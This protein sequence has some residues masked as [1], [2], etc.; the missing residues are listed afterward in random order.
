MEFRSPMR[1]RPLHFLPVILLIALFALVPGRGAAQDMPISPRFGLVNAYEDTEAARLSGAGWEIIT[2][3]W[4]E[5]QPT[6]PTDWTP[7]SEIDNWLSSAR[8]AG[9]EVVV[10]LV[11]TPGWAT[12]GESV[13]GVPRG[14]YLPV[15]DPGNAWGSFVSQAASYYGS[16]GVNRWVIWR[17]IDIPRGRQGA[18]WDGSIEEYYQLVKVASVAA[19][20]AN[21]NALIHLGG[22]GSFDPG[23]F[24]RFLDIALDDP[25]APGSDYY[26]DV[27]TLHVFYSPE[28]VYTQIRNHYYLMDQRGIPLK[29]VWLNETNARPAVDSEV[30]PEDATFREHSRISMEQQAA[31]VMQAYA[32]SFA[33]GGTRTAVYRLVDDLD[34]DEDEAFGLVRADGSPRQ[35]FFTYRLAM[36]QFTGWVYARRVDETRPLIDYVRLT[37]AN[38]VTHVAWALTEEP[39]TLIIPARTRQATLLDLYGNRW[40]VQPED[41]GAYHLVV[42]G[43]ECNDPAFG[44]LVGGMPWLL[45]EDGI[46]NAPGQDPPAVTVEA[47]GALPTPEPGAALTATALAAPTDTPSPPDTPLAT[48]TLAATDEATS[49]PPTVEPTPS[50]TLIVCRPRS[51]KSLASLLCRPVWRLGLIPPTSRQKMSARRAFLVFY[52]LS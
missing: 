39:A 31:F 33:A 40:I 44:C 49:P 9:R 26:F 3:R 27:A 34:V 11:G 41:D 10:V 7:D 28:S 18:T 15:S 14:L 16:R 30:Y 22:V 29:E 47:G 50:P 13:T 38:K 48:E 46:A 52:H 6:G 21:P 25:T 4:D 12:S 35:A 17:D 36:E 19:K 43:A 20:N 51:Q 8:A 42:G 45:V 5:I 23:W 1:L 24:G 37:F 2:L 32:L